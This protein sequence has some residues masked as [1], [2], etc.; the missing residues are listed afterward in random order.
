M[1]VDKVLQ[2][3]FLNFLD[4]IIEKQ[5]SSNIFAYRKGRDARTCVAYTYSKL[6][7]YLYFKDISIASITIKKSFDHV[8]QRKVLA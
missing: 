5:L 1:P 7:R 3:M 8:L 4:V 2:Q 6:N